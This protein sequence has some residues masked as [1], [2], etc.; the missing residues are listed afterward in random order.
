MNW[1]SQDG[2]GVFAIIPSMPRVIRCFGLG[3]VAEWPIAPVC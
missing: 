1:Y 2:A 3:E